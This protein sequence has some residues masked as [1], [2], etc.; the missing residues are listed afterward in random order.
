MTV[1]RIARH[2][3]TQASRRA[4]RVLTGTFKSVSRLRSV[5]GNLVA[6]TNRGKVT[7]AEYLESIGADADLI[8][9]YAPTL[10]KHVKA[11]YAATHGTDPK[12]T[13]LAIVGHHLVRTYAYSPADLSILRA[14]TAGYGRVSHLANGAL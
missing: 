8:R 11:A 4:N 3:A 10:G 6:R 1:H 7:V 14:A 9:R 2:I 13:G 12:R 5:L